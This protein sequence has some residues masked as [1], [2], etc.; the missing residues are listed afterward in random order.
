MLENIKPKSRQKGAVSMLD[1]SQT[2][3]FNKENACSESYISP[4]LLEYVYSFNG[5]PEILL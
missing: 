4:K 1:R 2:S 5:V 3:K